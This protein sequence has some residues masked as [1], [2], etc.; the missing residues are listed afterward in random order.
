MNAIKPYTFLDLAA[1]VLGQSPTPMTPDDMWQFAKANGISGKLSSN[2]GQTPWQT[3]SARLYTFVKAKPDGLFFR[4]VGSPARFGLI[5]KHESVDFSNQ[6]TPVILPSTTSQSQI[7]H[8]RDLHPFLAYFAEGVLEEV[9]VKTIYHEKSKKLSFGEWL[10]PDIVG[11]KILSKNWAKDAREVAQSCGGNITR[12]YSFE[13]K[14][15]LKQSNLREAFFQCV[16]NSSWANEAWL[17]TGELESTNEFGKELLRLTSLFG[18]GV[19]KLD[20]NNP[21]ESKVH[22]QAKYRDD[23]DWETVTKLASHNSNFQE[24]LSN[25][26]LSVNAGDFVNKHQFDKVLDLDKLLSNNAQQS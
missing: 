19:I 23:I 22:I 24:F 8:E 25:V 5:G 4:A 26:K 20:V 15:Q 10:H 16:S 9:A 11:V 14:R 3:L 2:S 6:I 12:L 18:I 17:V 1:E 7:K 13:L 21:D